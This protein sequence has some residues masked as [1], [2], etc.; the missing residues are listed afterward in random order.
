MRRIAAISLTCLLLLG[1]CMSRA[2]MEE[3]LRQDLLDLRSGIERFH[4]DKGQHPD[5]LDDLVR[6][7][8]LKQIPEDPC[9]GKRDWVVNSCEHYKA[10]PDPENP[11]RGICDVHSACRKENK[12]GEPYKDW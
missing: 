6:A 11:E 2:E 5:T 3:R 9:T 12:G 7:G 8:Y 1:G 10:I 4:S